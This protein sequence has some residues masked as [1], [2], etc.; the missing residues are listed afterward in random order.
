VPLYDGFSVPQ[1]NP[2]PS[3]F[4]IE[5]RSALDH[6]LELSPHHMLL[7]LRTIAAPNL[8]LPALHWCTIGGEADPVQLLEHLRLLWCDDGDVRLSCSTFLLTGP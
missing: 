8:H 3:Y 7:N 4:H 6:R 5:T 1:T 2:S